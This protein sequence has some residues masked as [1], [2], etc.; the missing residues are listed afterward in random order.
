MS[1]IPIAS[2]VTRKGSRH[3]VSLTHVYR[4]PHG[5]LPL[6]HPASLFKATVRSIVV[7]ASTLGADFQTEN[8]GCGSNWPGSSSSLALLS[9]PGPGLSVPTFSRL[10]RRPIP[11]HHRPSAQAKAASHPD[12]RSLPEPA[13]CTWG[14]RKTPGSRFPVT[15]VIRVHLA[16]ARTDDEATPMAL[17]A[18][19]RA[20]IARELRH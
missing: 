11:S 2:R 4:F 8:L 12:Y 5:S 7:F 13:T 3:H 18:E 9:P 10:G 17:R 6:R 20:E 15:H 16:A 14:P 1:L 19:P